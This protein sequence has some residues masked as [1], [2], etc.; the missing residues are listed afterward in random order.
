MVPP[1]EKTPASGNQ[2]IWELCWQQVSVPGDRA[3]VLME[4]P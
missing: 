2:L 3:K 1:P 4:E